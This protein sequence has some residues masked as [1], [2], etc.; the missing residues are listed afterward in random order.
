MLREPD[1][2]LRVEHDHFVRGLFPVLTWHCL[3]QE[4]GLE[5]IDPTVEDPFAGE[6]AVFVAR[7]P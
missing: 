2:P 5:L 4:A 1:T 6:H 3:I 7:R